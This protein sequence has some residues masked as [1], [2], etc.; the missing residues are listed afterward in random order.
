MTGEAGRRQGGDFLPTYG[1][2]FEHSLLQNG[3][4]LCNITIEMHIALCW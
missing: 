1:K 3:T 2:E 4:T